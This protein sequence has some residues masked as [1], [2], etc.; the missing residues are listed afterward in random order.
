METQ[1][2][3]NLGAEWRRPDIADIT[4]ATVAWYLLHVQPQVPEAIA[5]TVAFLLL[6]CV[7]I[8]RR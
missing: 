3:Q 8:N 4:L 2:W 5:A 1:S 6:R 7:R